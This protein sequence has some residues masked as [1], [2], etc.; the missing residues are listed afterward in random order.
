MTFGHSTYWRG[1]YSRDET[2]QGQKLSRKYDILRPDCVDILQLS[3][4]YCPNMYCGRRL[5][6]KRM[7]AAS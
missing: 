7:D 1:N 3:E 2:I 4:V 5:I 6:V